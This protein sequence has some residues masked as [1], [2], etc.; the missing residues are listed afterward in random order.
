MNEEAISS[1][2]LNIGRVVWPGPHPM[3]QAEF[4]NIIFEYKSRGVKIEGIEG[5]LDVAISAPVGEVN[6]AA[7]AQLKSLKRKP[8]PGGIRAAHVHYNG[9]VFLLNKEDWKEFSGRIVEELKTK[10]ADAHAISYDQLMN[11]SDNVQE[12]I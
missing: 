9:D 8:F 1:T 12:I 11:L 7:K 2:A 5:N 3:F 10:M 4:A 6:A